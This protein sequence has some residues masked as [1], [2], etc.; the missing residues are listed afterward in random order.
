MTHKPIQLF[1]EMTSAC[2]LR[3]G[4]CY[5]RAGEGR[6]RQIRHLHLHEMLREFKELGGEF[7]TFSG[8]ES[9]LYREWRASLRCA[10]ILGLAPTLLTNATLLDEDD[11]FFVR[12]VGAR[13]AASLDGATSVTNDLVRGEGSF[14]KTV[15]SLRMVV[16]AGMGSSTILCFTPMAKN[17]TELPGV[18]EFAA[19]AGIGTVYLSLL[20]DRG[21][22]NDA[23]SELSLSRAQ[24]EELLWT[25]YTLQRDCPEV[26]LDCPNLR[27]FTE[28]LRGIDI[29]ADSLDRTIRVTAD[30]DVFLTA[31]LDDE[32]FHLG[33]YETGNLAELWYSNKVA[34]ALHA[35]AG[36]RSSIAECQSCSA[37]QWC[38]A[39]CATFAWRRNG[40]FF[41]VD[42]YCEPKQDLIGKMLGNAHDDQRTVTGRNS[43]GNQ[44]DSGIG[45]G[46]RT[47]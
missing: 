13:I 37:A 15:R 25:I 38:R 40:T 42:S 39:G 4:H 17:V 28:R 7:V 45:A 16:A 35:A 26:E 30:G 18:V 10:A 29:D 9:T 33:R 19:E 32:P 20:E 43:R 8:G 44:A 41:G 6:T 22:A 36:R 11:I 21:R 1:L 2:N 3:C 24:K 46:R 12:E 27:F 34:S 47:H 31:Y 23:G 14:D 5:V